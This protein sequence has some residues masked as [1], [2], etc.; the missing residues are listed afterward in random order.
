MQTTIDENGELLQELF[1]EE[2]KEK[3]EQSMDDRL[4]ELNGHILVD[5]EELTEKRFKELAKEIPLR[6]ST[7]E[8]EHPILGQRKDR[9]HYQKFNRR[10]K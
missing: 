6:E 3:L 1:K 2:S 4:K 9:P 7:V 8:D 5:R 10:F